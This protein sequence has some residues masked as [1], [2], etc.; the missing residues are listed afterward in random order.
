MKN[1]RVLFAKIVAVAHYNSEKTLKFSARRIGSAFEV[2]V[3]DAVTEDTVKTFF[4]GEMK[5]TSFDNRLRWVIIEK[6][7]G[8]IRC[9]KKSASADESLKELNKLLKPFGS[10]GF[11]WEELLPVV[12]SR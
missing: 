5:D 10:R 11:C 7:G 9:V 2:T 3:I 1:L 8:K 12:E 4:I 6:R